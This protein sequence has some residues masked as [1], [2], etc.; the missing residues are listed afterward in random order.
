MR[1]SRLWPLL[2][3]LALLGPAIW[4]WKPRFELLE[5]GPRIPDAII[6][7]RYASGDNLTGAAFYPPGL[8]C[9][10]ERSTLEKTAQAAALLRAQGLRLKI[11]DAYRPAA[12]QQHLWKTAGKPGFVAQPKPGQRWSWHCYGR[13][14]DATLCDASGR[15]LPMPTAFDDFSPAASSG[16]TGADPAVRDNLAKLQAAMAA[17]GLQKLGQEWWHFSNPIDP[18]PTA[19]LEWA[20]EKRVAP[21][22]P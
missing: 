11:W 2:A 4:L 14:L 9:L 19:P 22:A 6:E 16:Y 3:A 12:A 20:D 18:P 1:L 7:L 10:L 17:A 13:A 8:P 5:V 21:A 15:E